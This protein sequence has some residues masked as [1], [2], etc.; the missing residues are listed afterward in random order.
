[1]I[2]IFFSLFFVRKKIHFVTFILWVHWNQ[3]NVQISQVQAQ[4][5]VNEATS[6]IVQMHA[7]YTVQ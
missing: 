1:M 3:E 2:G 5:Q 7:D 4:A 6:G